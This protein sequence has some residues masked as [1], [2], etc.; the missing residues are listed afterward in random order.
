MVI[1]L[2]LYLTT[3]AVLMGGELNAEIERMWPTITRAQREEVRMAAER[4][5]EDDDFAV[6]TASPSALLSAAGLSPSSGAAPSASAAKPSPAKPSPAKPSPAKPS[7]AKPSPAKPGAADPGAADPG[8]A[9]PAAANPSEGNR[10]P[11]AP[12]PS[13]SSQEAPTGEKRPARAV[14]VDKTLKSLDRPRPF[15]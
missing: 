14:D 8:A 13:P 10:G 9:D 7:P 12:N 5:V 3:L 15:E 2:F 1:L 6:S 11:S 4:D